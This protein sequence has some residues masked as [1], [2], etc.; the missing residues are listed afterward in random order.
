MRAAVSKHWLLCRQYG[1]SAESETS[2]GDGSLASSN[3]WAWHST[4]ATAKQPPGAPEEIGSFRT[5]GTSHELGLSEASLLAL[6]DAAR[7][8]LAGA[9]TSAATIAGA[10]DLLRAAVEDESRGLPTMELSTIRNTRLDKL[11]ADILSPQ[12]HAAAGPS[13]QW[14]DVATAERLQRQ[15]RVR[16][17]EKYF[18]LD[19]SRYLALAKTGLL[20]DVEFHESARHY[21]RL[22]RAKPC[23]VLSEGEGNL[24]YEAG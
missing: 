18:E 12:N 15:W 13:C 6:C 7:A 19:Q 24:Q 4:S 5:L 1:D 8:G 23:Q 16:F 14:A 20:Q 17:R 2:D 9:D 11:L 22:W 21:G 10:M 3:R